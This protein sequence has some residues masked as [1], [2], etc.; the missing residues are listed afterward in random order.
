YIYIY[1]Q[2]KEEKNICNKEKKPSRNKNMCNII[3]TPHKQKKTRKRTPSSPQ[4][5]PK[6]QISKGRKKKK[7]NDA[8]QIASP[9]NRKRT[10]LPPLSTRTFFPT[11]VARPLSLALRPVQ[12]TPPP[13][14]ALVLPLLLAP[15]T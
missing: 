11:S 2:E 4:R 8:N 10:A 6:Q 15:L 1:I 12:L 5:H 7:R 14:L 3:I 13:P 9:R